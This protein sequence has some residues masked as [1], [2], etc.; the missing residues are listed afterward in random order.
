MDDTRSV[1]RTKIDRAGEQ[2]RK[3]DVP[4]ALSALMP[5]VDPQDVES[6]ASHSVEVLTERVRRVQRRLVGS[7][8]IDPS[9][10]RGLAQTMSVY[11]RALAG[12]RHDHQDATLIANLLTDLQF[13]R[14]ARQLPSEIRDRLLAALIH[15]VVEHAGES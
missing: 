1:I 7:S 6:R 15:A 2:L 3:G 11:V 9:S 5:G 4:G 10:S 8:P 14:L 13:G 12:M